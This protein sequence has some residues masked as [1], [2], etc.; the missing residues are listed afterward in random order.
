MLDQNTDRMWYVIGAVIIGAAIILILNGTM[1][2]IFAS[3]A[4]SFDGAAD[5][6]TELAGYAADTS[7]VPYELQQ[8]NV[9]RDIPFSD[10]YFNYL[11]GEPSGVGNHF[12]MMTDLV[13]VE[14]NTEY[15][16]QS[17]LPYDASIWRNFEIA[18]IYY[19]AS[20]TVI[21]GSNA[22]NTKSTIIT[23]PSNA[24]HIKLRFGYPVYNE[25]PVFNRP[26]Y[27]FAKYSDIAEV[28]G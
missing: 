20:G 16:A 7:G 23:T 17:N 24:T 11:T 10:G 12:Q 13:P 2:Q 26:G 25:K 1:P 6:S 21:P 15:Y 18:W 9:I 8:H 27:V 3:V 22:Y 28:V 5:K 19:D 4:E 14:P